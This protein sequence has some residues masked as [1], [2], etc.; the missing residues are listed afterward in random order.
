MWTNQASHWSDR[1]LLSTA[2][3][4]VSKQHARSKA[5]EFNLK[6]SL[7]HIPHLTSARCLPHLA[8]LVFHS[9]DSSASLLSLAMKPS[10][11]TGLSQMVRRLVTPR[12]TQFS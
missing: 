11:T 1:C 7:N 9:L 4:T 5:L 3:E 2:T 6:R 10:S 12:D 8:R